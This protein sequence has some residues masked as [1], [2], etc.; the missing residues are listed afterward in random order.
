M[1]DPRRRRLVIAV[2]IY[3]VVV[4]TFFAVIPRSR[5]LEHTPFNHFALLAETWLH[6]RLDLPEGPPPYAQNNDFASFQHRWFIAFPPFPALLILPFVWWGKTAEHVRDAQFFLW[7]SGIGPAVLF[8][9]LEKLRRMG[10]NEHGERA[11][12][13]L[14]LL[15]AFGSVYFFTA[16]QGTVW[17]AAHVVGVAVGAIYLLAALEGEYPAVA[18]LMIG[19]GFLTRTPLLFATPLFVFEACRT[20][21]TED[22]APVAGEG[23]LARAR[24]FLRRLDKAKVARRFVLFALP[25]AVCI[26]VALWHNVA[27]FGRV[28]DFGYEYLTVAW[29]ARMKK[30]GIFSYHYLARNLG[31]VLTGLP[32]WDRQSSAPLQVNDHGLALWVTTPLYLWLLWPKRRGPVVVALYVTAIAVALPGLFYQN[33][34]WMQ[35]GYRFSNDYAVFLFALIAVIGIRYGKLFTAAAIWSVAL[36]AFGAV[37]FDTATFRKF[38]YEDPSQ[39]IIYQQD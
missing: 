16:V 32:F 7:L 15:F 9:A 33:T 22:V 13:V 38:Y 1:A 35:F 6:G 26:A 5:I 24:S 3:L 2:G 11:N 39:R 27:R 12:I 8:L 20:A 28:G 14:A 30:W 10:V 37:T 36:N 25:F 31:I 17:F 21:L 18:G 34:G 4:G 19:L 23:M 29:Q